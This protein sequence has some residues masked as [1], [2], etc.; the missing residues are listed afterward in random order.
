MADPVLMAVDDHADTLADLDREL[1]DR[2]GRHYRVD[3]FARPTDACERLAQL[4]ADD[5]PVALVLAGERLDGMSG[6]ALLD[7]ARRLHP[8]SR[9]G[10]LVAWGEWGDSEVGEAIFDSIARGRIDYYVLR[11]SEPPDELFHHAISGLLLDWAESQR[12]SPHTVHIV[13][14]SWS[15]R[16]YELRETLGR[17]AMPHSFHLS[18]SE[19]GSALLAQAGAPRA[20]P[21]VVFP[22][23]RVLRDPSNAE[24]AITA[25]SPAHPDETEYDLVIAGAGPAGLSAAVYG[26][27]EGFSTLVVD[28]GGIGGQ[29]TS[30]SLI[31]NYLGFPRGVSGRRLAQDAYQQAWVFGAKF[32]FMHPVVDVRPTPGGI[33][34]E[35]R[36][37]GW[38]HARAVL[39]STGVEY[40]RVGVPALEELNGRGVYYGGTASEAAGVT[41]RDVFVVGGA[42][43]A[44]QA[45]LHLA[46][47]ARHVT[48]VVRAPSLDAGMSQYLVHQVLATPNIT[49]RVEH[50]VVDGG[51][52]GRLE[53]LVRRH[54]AAA[55]QTRESAD[56]LFLL[57]GARP[58][59]DWLPREVRRDEQGY[60]LTGADV[61]LDAWPLDRA[62][63]PLESS[64]PRLFV[65]GDTRHDSVKRV[66]SA[67]G[68]GSVTIQHLHQLFASDA[69]AAHG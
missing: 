27:S 49:V 32:V 29:S 36:D 44:G 35:V 53:H 58:H 20:L 68:E 61:P 40:R 16:A 13:G 7:E 5:E 59:T 56:A 37:I 11:P 64:M 14:D 33:A 45:A 52:D 12:T 67:V 34:L 63:F 2:Y 47:Y 15:G 50:E 18:D 21:L 26:A 24:I 48:I 54:N 66:A 3:C 4:A 1:R 62:P 6:S 30:S 60:V 19:T 65:A 55:T 57:I 46:R 25:G 31:R 10:L 39:L 42:N 38:V 9:R 8:H 69:L 22:D 23:G 17:C 28:Q 51:G 41:D 43:S